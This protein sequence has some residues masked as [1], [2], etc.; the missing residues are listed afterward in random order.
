M[1]DSFER[2]PIGGTQDRRLSSG[3]RSPW[4]YEVVAARAYDIWRRHGCPAGTSFQ[5]W[6]AAEAE[7]RCVSAR[8]VPRP[9]AP[10]RAAQAPGRWRA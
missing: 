4:P 5:D 3:D 7:L 8:R 2:R 6:L 1:D 10:S 9:P